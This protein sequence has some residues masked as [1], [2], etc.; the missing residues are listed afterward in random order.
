VSAGNSLPGA[1]IIDALPGGRI[2]GLQYR[3]P[4]LDVTADSPMQPRNLF[5]ECSHA[6][7]FTPVGE[8]SQKAATR[9]NDQCSKLLHI[10]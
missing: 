5:I 2:R 9:A 8:T 7:L 6:V 1:S 4:N 10:V 3:S